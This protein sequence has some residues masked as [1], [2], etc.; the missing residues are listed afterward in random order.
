MVFDASLGYDPDEWEECP[1][2]EHFMVFSFF[3]R[4][5]LS[6]AAIAFVV[7]FFHLIE[8]NKTKEE[9][10]EKKNDPGRDNVDNVEHPYQKLKKVPVINKKSISRKLNMISVRK[11]RSR[12]NSGSRA[13]RETQR[14]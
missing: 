7:L 13:P 4:L 14:R 8:N 10:K 2:K 3:T 6:S 12:R 5:L 11:N 1:V 9:K